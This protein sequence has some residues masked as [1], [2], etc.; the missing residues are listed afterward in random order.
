MKAT[1]ATYDILKYDGA[2]D[3]LIRGQVEGYVFGGVLGV[4]RQEGKH[5]TGW[6]V[7]H[8]G[9][10]RALQVSIPTLKEAKEIAA[11][12]LESGVDWT[13]TRDRINTEPVRSKAK[14]AVG[15]R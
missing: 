9:S 4:N 3:R 5:K 12:A 14:A 13:A 6:N 11:R 1:K 7:T 8:L 2:P 15:R 10:G